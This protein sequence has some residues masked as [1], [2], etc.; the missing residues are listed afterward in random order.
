MRAVIAI[1]GLICLAMLAACSGGGQ[2]ESAAEE[3]VETLAEA[4]LTTAVDTVAESS[5]AMPEVKKDGYL[6]TL[7]EAG[8][9]VFW[10]SGCGG[11]KEQTSSGSTRRA[12]REFIYTCDRDGAMGAGVSIRVFRDAHDPDG[13]PPTAEM[14]AEMVKVQLQKSGTSVIR[15][16]HLQADGI[17]G[18]DV[19]A[20]EPDGAGEVW[21]RG[22]LSGSDV[23]ILMA[24]DK[25]GGLFTDPEFVNF[26]ASFR[27]NER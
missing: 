8:F 26:F 6:R 23:F 14:V 2:E 25:S 21:M 19:Q 15:Q 1:T 13:A 24:F 5:P 20:G 7:D 4:N 27:A 17:E 18:V 16:R 3:P 11:L 9:T 10:P 22:L 12:K